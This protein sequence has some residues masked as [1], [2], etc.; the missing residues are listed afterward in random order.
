[1]CPFKLRYRTVGCDAD[2]TVL[3]LVLFS[4]HAVKDVGQVDRDSYL[5]PEWS[6]NSRTEEFLRD[7]RPIRIKVQLAEV[8]TRPNPCRVAES[9]TSLLPTVQEG[10]CIGCASKR[11]KHA[12]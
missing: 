7:F 6:E 11:V 4:Y 3:L 1:M 5:F 10:K 2:F 8:F 9:F 12:I